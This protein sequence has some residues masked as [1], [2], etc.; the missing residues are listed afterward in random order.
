MPKITRVGSRVKTVAAMNSKPSDRNVVGWD[1]APGGAQGTDHT[2]P[3]ANMGY[4]KT[5]IGRGTLIRR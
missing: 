5:P 1:R 2:T 3:R 4:K